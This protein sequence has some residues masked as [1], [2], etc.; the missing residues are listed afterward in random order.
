MLLAWAA[1]PDI[2]RR[3]GAAG[4]R[5]VSAEYDWEQ[6]GRRLVAFVLAGSGGRR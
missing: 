3:L 1:E 6:E 4:R 2:P 5:L